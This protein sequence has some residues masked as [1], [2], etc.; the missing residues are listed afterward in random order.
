MKQRIFLI[1]FTCLFCVSLTAGPAVGEEFNFE[2][3]GEGVGYTLLNDIVDLFKN[4]SASGKGGLKHIETHL[5]K[6]WWAAKKARSSNLIDEKFYA[7]YKNLL[8]VITLCIIIPD[9][10]NPIIES[11]ISEGISK[12]DIPKTEGDQNVA[13]LSSIARALSEE[14]LS[15]K[16]YLDTKAKLKGKK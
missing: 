6:W 5:I 2:V 9:R 13:G 10:N 4:L 1:V 7:R 3:K 16:K 8:E 12:F 14:I 15:L 11:I